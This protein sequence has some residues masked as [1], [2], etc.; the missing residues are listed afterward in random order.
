MI[1]ILC[2]R[3]AKELSATVDM[4][5]WSTAPIIVSENATKDAL[6][7]ATT[8]AFAQ[9]TG[10]HLF[11]YHC[12]DTHNGEV[13]S[14]PDLKQH[15]ADL[16]SNSTGHRLGRIPLVIGMPVM[17]M[18]NFDVSNGIVNGRIRTLKS[19]CYWT[20]SDGHRHASSCVVESTGISGEA[21]PGLKKN[22]AVALQDET[23]MTF[24]HPHSHKKLKIKRT[25]IP[26]SMTAYKL[27]GLLLD[28]AV[29]D[30]ESCTG[31]ESRYVMISRVRLLDGLMV[32]RPF[33]CSKISCPLQQ[34]VRDE[35][36]RQRLLE[37]ASLA[38]FGEGLLAEDA[39]AELCQRNL[40]EL[41]FSENTSLDLSNCNLQTLI[42]R[43]DHVSR[44]V[45]CLTRDVAVPPTAA[46]PF[47]SETR[48]LKRRRVTFE[49]ESGK[50]PFLCILC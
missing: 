28:R 5:A 2:G 1:T 38:R 12:T 44:Q 40:D 22:Q 18:A 49:G 27:Q 41:L 43:E 15:L 19:V 16:T 42:Q 21:L 35:L 7:V 37:L 14:D 36:K 3:L 17:I 10:R 25:Q 4:N 24:I 13:I 34:D 48:A 30:I 20:D 39:T 47:P 31:S 46:H 29:V 9:E 6:N 11:W 33:R 45:R 32:L 26:I 23:D 8:E 50:W